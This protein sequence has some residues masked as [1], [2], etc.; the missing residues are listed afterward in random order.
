MNH[1]N[2]AEAF[3]YDYIFL[4][5][6]CSFR[7]LPC[8][9]KIHKLNWPLVAFGSEHHFLYLLRIWRTIKTIHRATNTR[10]FHTYDQIIYYYSHSRSLALITFCI[11]TR[12]NNKRNLCFQFLQY[13]LLWSFI[14]WES[15]EQWNDEN[16]FLPPWNLCTV[17]HNLKRETCWIDV[18]RKSQIALTFSWPVNIWFF[19]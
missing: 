17:D 13:Y 10:A 8:I 18:L 12:Y 9:Y 4:V 14:K 1:L 2:T 7:L 3:N 11:F 16:V 19:V 6:C 5:N 15:G